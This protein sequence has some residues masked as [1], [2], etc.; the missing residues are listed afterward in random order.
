MKRK[1]ED[2]PLTAD[3]K[4][5]VSTEIVMNMFG[6]YINISKGY[7][8]GAGVASGLLLEYLIRTDKKNDGVPFVINEDELYEELRLTK[9]EWKAA[10]QRLIDMQLLEL[11]EINGKV[12]Y[13]IARNNIAFFLAQEPSIEDLKNL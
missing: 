2:Y 13:A 5:D 10:E 8:Y 4:R 3:G 11:H 7:C 12:L 6:D 1:P 9:S